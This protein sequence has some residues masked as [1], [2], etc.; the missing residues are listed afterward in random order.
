MKHARSRATP[1]ADKGF[2]FLSRHGRKNKEKDKAS[3][4]IMGHDDQDGP[5]HSEDRD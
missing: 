1:R 5:E 2:G 4:K 3:L